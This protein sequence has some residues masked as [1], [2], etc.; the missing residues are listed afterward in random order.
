M[1]PPEAFESRFTAARDANTGQLLL[2][3]ARLFHE[4]GIA[5]IQANGHP[6]LRASHFT[7]APHFE[8]AGSRITDVAAR[9]GISKQA[10]GQIVDELEALGYVERIPD[11]T[12]ARARLVV[13][14]ALGRSGLFDG[15]AALARVEA[16]VKAEIP[17]LAAF[18]EGLAAIIHTLRPPT[19]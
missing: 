4:A 9:A 17:D 1:P 6:G 15:L 10:V 7:L 2:L 14:T 11:P 12:D 18:R 3:A 5:E 16:R 19:P 8:L 13:F